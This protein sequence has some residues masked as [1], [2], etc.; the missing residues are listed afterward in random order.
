MGRTHAGNARRL[1]LALVALVAMA[2]MP[3]RTGKG[4]EPVRIPDARFNAATVADAAPGW[5]MRSGS[6]YAL[7]A[8]PTGVVDMAGV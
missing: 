1:W 5:F 3:A 2:V 6:D 8:L 4:A 7:G